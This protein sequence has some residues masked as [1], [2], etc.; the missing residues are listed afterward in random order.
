MKT[1][2]LLLLSS[3]VAGRC[4]VS[5]DGANPTPVEVFA[6]GGNTFSATSNMQFTVGLWLKVTGNHFGTQASVFNRLSG[7]AGWSLQVNDSDYFQMYCYGTPATYR[8]SANSCFVRNVWNHIAVT[9]DG[10]SVGTSIRFYVNGVET[11]Y[12]TTVSGGL[13][14]VQ[15]AGTGFYIGNQGGG[16]AT[17]NGQFMEVAIWTNVLTSVEL[18][19]LSTRKMGMPLQV[20]KVHLVGYWPMNNGPDRNLTYAIASDLSGRNDI[21]FFATG[22]TAPAWI[23]TPFPYP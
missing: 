15:P 4:A 6:T 13:P 12:G 18:G 11:G 17:L 8:N 14:L 5:M 23:G 1:I 7:S 21:M 16:S 20:R 10:R 2:A 3:L 22:T 19:V 9:W